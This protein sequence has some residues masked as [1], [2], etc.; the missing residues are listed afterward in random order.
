MLTAWAGSARANGALPSSF[1][2]LLPA[3]R[4]QEIVL[5]TSFGMIISEDGGKTW[6]WTCE[7]PQ[8]NFGYLY[9]VGPSPR[10][11]FYG[12]SPDQGLALSDD[13]SCTWKRAGGVLDTLVASDV[14][15]DRTNGDRVVAVA[16]TFDPETLEIGTPSIFASADAGTTFG[17]NPLYAAP[18]GATIV[19][20]EIAQ[21]NPQIVYAAM[22]L[23]P[24]K[25]PHLLRSADSG[26]TWTDINVE[27]GLGANE[28]RI[29]AVD[30][31]D[32]NVLYLRVIVGNMEQLAVTRDGGMTFATP[33]TVTGPYGGALSAFLR[34]ESGTVLL[35]AFM[36][37]ASGGMD[38]VGY[39][40]T[41]GGHTFGPWTLSPQPRIFGLAERGGVLYVAGKNFSDGWALATSRDEGV[42]I[43]PISS[44]GDVRGIKACAMAVC[45]DA[46]S[47]VAS[48]GVWTNDVC[49]YVAPPPPP[50]SSSGCHCGVGGAAPRGTAG[51]GLLLA[52]AVALHRRRRRR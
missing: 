8:T 43:T 37:Q 51:A 2:I 4:P 35:G 1:G 19:S 39:R 7:Q 33:V 5:A 36:K 46:C 26:Q 27:P 18:T 29:L 20:I 47:L 50:P 52:V 44:Y 9:N 10:D 28:F 6:L 45:G 30:P 48:Q 31:A 11:R 16:A 41:D 42:T 32:P 21:S 38:G 15:V 25:H 49:T 23:A 12:L 3:D 22:Y 13:G 40:S 34:M 14:F 17:P 24:D